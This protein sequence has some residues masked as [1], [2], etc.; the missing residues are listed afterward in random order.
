MTD[1]ESSRPSGADQPAGSA[2]PSSEATGNGARAP[3]EMSVGELVFEVSDRASI[4]IREEIELAKTEVTEKVTGLFRASFLGITAFILFMVL[5][6]MLFITLA[7]LVNDL[8]FS[9]DS[10]VG[11][12][13]STFLVA[14]ATAGTAWWALLV[15]KKSSPP[16][17]DM[18]LEEARQIKDAFDNESPPDTQAD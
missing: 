4:L 3:E 16:T 11:Y 12:V 6:G 18:A 2:P 10:W 13:I 8:F 9:K 7:V 14:A 1:G 17:P 15:F 5:L